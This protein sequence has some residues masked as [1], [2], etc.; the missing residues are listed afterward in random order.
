MAVFDSALLRKLNR[1]L[2]LGRDEIAALARL[3]S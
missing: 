3:E 1:F 2:P